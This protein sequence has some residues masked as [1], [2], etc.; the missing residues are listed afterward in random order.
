M[1]AQLGAELPEL[2]DDRLKA[3]GFDAQQLMGDGALWFRSDAFFKCAMP[4]I[5]KCC[6]FLCAEAKLRLGLWTECWLS[7]SL[8]V[9]YSLEDVLS[10][11]PRWP[12][13]ITLG[14]GLPE[15]LTAAVQADDSFDEVFLRSEWLNSERLQ[16]KLKGRYC[17]AGL[18]TP[19]QLLSRCTELRELE[20]D[21]SGSKMRAAASSAVAMLQLPCL[22]S[23]KLEL[24]NCD[25]DARA[26]SSAL[27]QMNLAELRS[28]E[29]NLRLC[30]LNEEFCG[31]EAVAQ[32]LSKL[33]KLNHISL[34]WTESTLDDLTARAVA[35]A[36]LKMPDLE[37]AELLLR[38]SVSI[39]GAQK[40]SI[41][42]LS[43][44]S[45][46]LKSWRCDL[47][48][49]R[50]TTTVDQPASLPHDVFRPEC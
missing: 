26:L 30:S 32:A 23:L 33:V 27:D 4:S 49:R 31:L 50:V 19:L 9:G 16:L 7:W 46:K 3:L 44:F 38:S 41:N 6:Q 48:Q 12:E 21:L 8:Q 28:L 47:T 20:L 36:M 43:D 29:L 22:R 37:S 13:L 15:L 5:F 35:K 45:S 2:N 17:G 14:K 34:N 24:S 39:V 25:P 11:K 10:A 18:A 1:K 42:A 40:E